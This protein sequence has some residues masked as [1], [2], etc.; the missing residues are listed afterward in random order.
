MSLSEDELVVALA[1][2][3]LLAGTMAFVRFRVDGQPVVL[4]DLV[5][6]EGAVSDVAAFARF[7]RSLQALERP[8]WRGALFG[9]PW[10]AFE[11]RSEDGELHA[12]CAAPA[13][14]AQLVRALLLSAVSGIEATTA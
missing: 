11:F 10:V 2:I 9:Q 13:S 14:Q 3:A 8:G 6:R 12:R 7:F 5:L 4:F 1:L